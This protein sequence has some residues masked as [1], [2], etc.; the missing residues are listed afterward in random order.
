MINH[1]ITVFLLGL[2]TLLSS[3]AIAQTC[4]QSVVV[5]RDGYANVRYSPRARRDNII[6][7]LPLGIA[8]EPSSQRYGWVQIQ[9]PIVGWLKQGQV[10]KLSCDAAFNLLLEKGVPAIAHLGSQA[11]LGNATSAEAFLQMARGLDGVMAETYGT[12]LKDWIARN[13]SFLVAVLQRQTPTIRYAVLD[14]INTNLGAKQSRD[15]RQFEQFLR[16]LPANHVIIRDWKRYSD[17]K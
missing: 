10:S 5:S 9:S 15:R 11:I 16:T 1:K 17:P 7:T 3:P 14:T 12:T 13:P 8:L 2:T 6:G 4:Q